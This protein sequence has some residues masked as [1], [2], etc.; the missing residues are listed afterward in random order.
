MASSLDILLVED[1]PADADLLQEMLAELSELDWHLTHVECFRDALARL[2]QGSFDIVL[3]DLG[4]PDASGLGMISQIH[5]IAPMLPVVVLTGLAD[6]AVGLDALRQG[7]QDYLFKGQIDDLLL[8][9][10]LRY[11]MERSRTQWVMQQQAT[12][13]AASRD[14]IAILNRHQVYV[15]ANQA[16]AR[17]YGYDEAAVI[18]GK[19]GQA[20]YGAAEFARI[21]Q[22]AG[23]KLECHGYW[24]GE[25]VG[26]RQDGTTFDQELSI[27]V[28][29]D[30]GWVCIVRDIRDRKYAE[31]NLR[32]S[33]ERYRKLM[34]TAKDAILVTDRQTGV[35]IDANLAAEELLGR[36]LADILG[37]HQAQLY[38]LPGSSLAS[39]ASPL[40]TA[41]ELLSHHPAI[42]SM[43]CHASGS[44]IPVEVTSSAFQVDERELILGIFRDIRDRKAAEIALGQ[45][46]ARLQAFLDNAETVIY[47]KDT[48]GAYSLVN[49]KFQMLFANGQTSV[50]GK[51]DHDLFPPDVADVICA[52]DQKVLAAKTSLEFEEALPQTDYLHT[53]LSVKFPLFDP[54]GLPYGVGGILTDITHRKQAETRVLQALAKEKELNELKSR[55]ISTTSHEFRT[56]LT[57]IL[58]STELLEHSSHKWPD[59]KRRKHYRQIKAA[60]Q[61]MTQLLDD[62]LTISKSEAGKLSL[63]PT[64]IDL[65]R[66]CRR[67]VEEFQAGLGQHHVI[68]FTCEGHSSTGESDEKVLR[69]IL[70]NLLSNAIKY[71]APGSLVR[72][73][74]CSQNGVA[75]LRIQDQGIGIPDSDQPHLFEPFHRA[76]NV[77][78]IAGTGL[79][80][81]IAK[82]AAE[83]HGGELSVESLVNVGTLCTVRLPLNQ[84]QA[85]P[86]SGLPFNS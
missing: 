54:S 80:L 72:L 34:T 73:T 18:N 3:L 44:P 36:P 70:E 46:E 47:L 2:Q 62:V 9:R 59:E 67:L 53:Y 24:S 27:T 19:T 57:T 78:T 48:Q 40:L 11:A 52:N 76:G 1:N 74:L 21:Q 61:H 17:L 56:P 13:I 68:Q 85:Q 22:A 71:S 82:R 60:V 28:L 38:Q 8:S 33:E 50:I 83:L 4:L 6:E 26:Q 45:S 39:I 63:K 51:T 14:G 32:K 69:Q 84:V 43:I 41:G 64:S 23:A 15:Y 30:G 5:H 29:P 42:E 86:V 31:D 37:L 49:H 20:F 77:G 25:V 65:E 7:A 35:I 12:A 66:F 10:A 58:G 16:F 79:G 81:A 75:T 55:F